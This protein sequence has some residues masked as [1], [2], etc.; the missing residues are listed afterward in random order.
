MLL[1]LRSAVFILWL[2]VTVIPWSLAAV[3]GSVFTR[4]APLYWLCA[5]W[6][7][8]SVLGAKWICGVHWRCF[9]EPKSPKEDTTTWSSWAEPWQSGRGPFRL[10]QKRG[11]H[12]MANLRRGG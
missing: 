5:G 7:K 8:L 12:P 6:L 2:I 9:S 10:I 3:I 11:I 4:G 1:Y